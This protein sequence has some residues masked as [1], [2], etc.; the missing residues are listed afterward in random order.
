MT[1]VSKC[2]HR[3]EPTYRP[4]FGD[5]SLSRPKNPENSSSMSLYGTTDTS[6]YL[7]A[8]AAAAAI[9]AISVPNDGRTTMQ[10]GTTSK[11]QLRC[12][13]CKHTHTHVHAH[14]H[15]HARARARARTPSHQ[16]SSPLSQ[17]GCAA[18]CT[19]HTP[20]TTRFSL[21]YVRN[22]CATHSSPTTCQ[23]VSLTK[24]FCEGQPSRN[25]K[26]QGVGVQK[27][28]QAVWRMSPSTQRM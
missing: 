1:R 16:E 22:T 27:V 14:T 8:A 11:L 25:N 17:L 24:K 10:G 26:Q 20:I 28:L 6:G 7:L 5:A 4:T 15:T 19:A 21:T 23:N 3:R 12:H 9:H 18:A 2:V 13:A